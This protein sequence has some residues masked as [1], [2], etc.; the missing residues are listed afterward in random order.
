VI[1]KAKKHH[2]IRP[3]FLSYPHP[4]GWPVQKSGHR[5]I[6]CKR[7]ILPIA[8][9]REGILIIKDI[10]KHKKR[11]PREAKNYTDNQLVWSALHNGYYVT[12][13]YN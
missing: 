6:F 11:P 2:F 7:A 9:F 10:R 8:F 1:K 5:R 4:S 3:D 13:E 12:T